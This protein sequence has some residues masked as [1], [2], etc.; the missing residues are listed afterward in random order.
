VGGDVVGLVALDLIL[1]VVAR[2]AMAVSLVIEIRMV[3]PDNPACH[4]TGLGV[5]ADMIADSV[6]GQ[7]RN[8][9]QSRQ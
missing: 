9:I 2:S 8:S 6:S 7:N 5:P 4:M 3:D 1:G